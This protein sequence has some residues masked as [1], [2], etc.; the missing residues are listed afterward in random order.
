M[1]YVYLKVSTTQN[2]TKRESDLF[3]RRWIHIKTD[4]HISSTI[5][6]TTKYSAALKSLVSDLNNTATFDSLFKIKCNNPA[7]EQSL[8]TPEMRLKILSLI[9]KYGC[10]G[11]IIQSD[12]QFFISVEEYDDLKDKFGNIESEDD[13]NEIRSIIHKDLSRPL[14]IFYSLLSEIITN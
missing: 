12:G 6:V 4:I 8:L 14:I 2:G 1:S 10:F 11:F 13:F 9:E 7:V 3:T 5:N